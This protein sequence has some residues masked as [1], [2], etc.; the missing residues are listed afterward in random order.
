MLPR[1]LG[2]RSLLQRG[3]LMTDQR[4]ISHPRRPRGTWL[5]LVYPPF[6]SLLVGAQ[7]SLF[8]HRWQA[9]HPPRSSSNPTAPT[10]NCRMISTRRSGYSRPGWVRRLG[11]HRIEDHLCNTLPLRRRNPAPST[12]E[13]HLSQGQTPSRCICLLCRSWGVVHLTPRQPLTQ[14][15]HL[16]PRRLLAPILLLKEPKPCPGPRRTF[17]TT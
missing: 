6:F 9:L 4:G 17:R 13:G 1:F 3:H 8:R 7:I 5:R 12:T 14:D 2:H 15:H 10:G 11:R 16:R